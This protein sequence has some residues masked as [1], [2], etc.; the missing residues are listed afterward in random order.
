MLEDDG[1]ASGAADAERDSLLAAQQ[2][3]KRRANLALAVIPVLVLLITFLFW[4]QTWFGRRLSASEMNQYLTDT[5]VPHKTQ[6]ALSQL[7]DEMAQGNPDARRW[8]PRVLALAGDKETE[9]RVMSA[10]VMGHDNHSDEFHRALAKLLRDPEPMVRRNAALALVRFGDAAGEG[11]LVKMLQP[12]ELAAP[13]AGKIDYR[14]RKTD[15]VQ[16][17][18]VV[19]R[20]DTGAAKPLD[21]RSPV[22]GV[23]ERRAVE[24]GS[25]VATG[26]TIAV[27]NPSEQEV[28]ESLR[29]LYLVGGARSLAEV[30]RFARGVPGISDRVRQQ[31]ALTAQAI[32][33]REANGR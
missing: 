12:Y 27:I 18:H 8:Y 26:E 15:E 10:W 2:A 11:E 9:F 6:H 31:A 23:F 1:R 33:K 25:A 29:G 30:E 7:A 22:E 13:A 21:V 5:S 32:Q 3:A 28:W 14:L 24:D 19:A 16:T 4:Y 17:N 20:I